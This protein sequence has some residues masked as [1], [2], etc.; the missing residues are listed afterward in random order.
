MNNIPQPRVYQITVTPLERTV[1]FYVAEKTYDRLTFIEQIVV[2]LKIEG[3]DNQDIGGLLGIKPAA[4][5]RIL[6]L[7]RV[8]LAKSELTYQI[9]LK[10]YYREQSQTVLDENELK[11]SF[12]TQ[13]L[14]G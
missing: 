11:D 8:K 7:I 9:E 10:Q 2:D 5:K 6:D 1:G 14:M 13:N 4:I 3:F 12:T